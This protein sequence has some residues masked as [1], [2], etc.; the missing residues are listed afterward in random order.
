MVKNP[1]PSAGD[2]VDSGSIPGLERS[3]GVGSGNPSNILAWKVLWPEE[4]GG[5]QS[6]GPQ[7]S[8]MMS[9]Q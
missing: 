1:P 7:E 8:N 2:S 9:T 3:S 6:M 4:P 5:L